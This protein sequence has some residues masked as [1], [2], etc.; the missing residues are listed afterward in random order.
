M[1]NSAPLESPCNFH[2]L[3]KIHKPKADKT[4]ENILVKIQVISI[5]LISTLP[6]CLPFNQSVKCIYKAIF[7]H[8]PM[9]QSAVQKLSLKPQTASN[10]GVEA[11]WL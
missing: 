2:Q 3:S 11:R 5:A 8:Q 7:L 1:Q 9:S 4:V 6:V 10:A